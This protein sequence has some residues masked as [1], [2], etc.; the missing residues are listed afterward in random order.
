M[1]DFKKTYIL[2]FKYEIPQYIVGFLKRRTLFKRWIKYFKRYLFIIL[3]G[4]KKLELFS[5]LPKHQDILWINISA[6]SFGD[7]LMDLSSRILLEGRNIDLFISKN[8][9]DIYSTDT[10]FNNV[11]S[12]EESVSGN[13]YNLVILDSYS[14]RS[15]KVKCRVAPKANFIGMF[16]YFNGPEVNRVLF[17]FH[18]MNNLLGY[19][20]SEKEINSSARASICISKVD[21]NLINE[22]KVPSKYIAIVL[23]GEWGYRTYRKWDKVIEHIVKKNYHI[24][25]AL[26]GSDNAKVIANKLSAQFSSNNVFNYVSSYTFNQTAQI[27]RQADIVLCCDGGLMHAANASNKTIVPLFARLSSKMQLTDCINSFPLFDKYDVN[28][29]SVEAIVKQYYNAISFADNHLQDE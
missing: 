25:I 10:I 21:Q 29:I 28:N 24:N 15:I 1:L 17:S 13:N 18:Q 27:I 4:Q 26:L 22:I 19:Q 14:T 23:G 9:S 20:K 16:G 3:N 7:S 12:N 5:I 8:I 2:P 6:P 11:Y